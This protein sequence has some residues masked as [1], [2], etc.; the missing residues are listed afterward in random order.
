[1]NGAKVY[2]RYCGRVPRTCDCAKPTSK[3]QA[4]W[5]RRVPHV[6]YQAAWMPSPYKRA[7]PP[8]IKARERATLRRHYPRWY[9][10]L[11]EQYGAVCG[12]CGAS[13]A[14][15]VLDHILPIAKG[16]LSEL[17]NVQL[18]CAECNRLKGKLYFDCRH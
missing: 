17:E 9:Q 5:A 3:L 2:C 4:F 6:E 16:G 14:K 13:A 11:V 12:H 18:L 7:V 1:M 8:Q 10:G 15:L